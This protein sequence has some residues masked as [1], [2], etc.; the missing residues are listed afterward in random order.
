MT[1]YF[2]LWLKDGNDCLC[3]YSSFLRDRL[4]HYKIIL[5]YSYAHKL[6]VY[7]SIM[8]KNKILRNYEMPLWSLISTIIHEMNS[9]LCFSLVHR[10]DP[11]HRQPP[12]LNT[13]GYLLRTN[14]GA[15]SLIDRFRLIR[16][17]AA[18][19]KTGL[20]ALCTF[21]RVARCGLSS[22]TLFIK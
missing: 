16:V 13:C 18:H 4:L 3:N 17:S 6:Y 15:S 21:T 5:L 20:T 10:C 11:L 2:L 8:F 12:R 1:T 9:C 14:G 22:G 19:F 7:K